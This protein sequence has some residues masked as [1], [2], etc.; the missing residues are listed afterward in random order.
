MGFAEYHR[1]FRG[2][3]P[4]HCTH[5]SGF[6]EQTT[7]FAGSIGA[8][9][10]IAQ[11]TAYAPAAKRGPLLTSEAVSKAGSAKSNSQT[12]LVIN[13]QGRSARGQATNMVYL[14]WD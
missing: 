11:P 10:N 3:P 13:S 12:R 1:A 7:K 14:I 2:M 9:T 4:G 5:S 6:R 8:V